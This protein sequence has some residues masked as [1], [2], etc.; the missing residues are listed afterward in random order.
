M[1]NLSPTTQYGFVVEFTNE[2]AADVEAS[3][4]VGTFSTFG[5]DIVDFDFAFGSCAHSVSFWPIRGLSYIANVLKP[6]FALLLGDLIYSDI[7]IRRK[8][9]EVYQ[10]SVQDPGYLDLGASVPLFK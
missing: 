9:E 7:P 3:S 5:E 1:E 6:S 4:R 10:N 8:F 2:K